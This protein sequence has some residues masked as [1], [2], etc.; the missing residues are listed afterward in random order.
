MTR[1][2]RPGEPITVE[3]DPYLQ[4]VNMVWRERDYAIEQIH[5]RWEIDHGWWEGRGQLQR[6]YFTIATT[7]GLLCVIFYDRGRELWFLSKV[8]D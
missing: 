3:V 2:W 5:Q 1:L 7:S 8:Y 6:R 4:P